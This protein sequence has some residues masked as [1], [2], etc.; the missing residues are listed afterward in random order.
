[1]QGAREGAGPGEAAAPAHER[2]RGGRDTC[3]PCLLLALPQIGFTLAFFT[4][5][6]GVL[7]VTNTPRNKEVS[8]PLASVAK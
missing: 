4:M 6:R 3:A 5:T 8:P 7:Y 2:P 1:M